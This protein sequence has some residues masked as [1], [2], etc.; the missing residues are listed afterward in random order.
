ML[1]GIF[2][3]HFICVIINHL[4]IFVKITKNYQKQQTNGDNSRVEAVHMTEIWK[5]ECAV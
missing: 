3:Q 4:K 5:H 1:M 2:Y